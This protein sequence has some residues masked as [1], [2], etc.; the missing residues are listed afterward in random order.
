MFLATY[1]SELLVC[2]LGILDLLL[3]FPQERVVTIEIKK[4]FFIVTVILQEY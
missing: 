4:Y 2:A 1:V 3:L